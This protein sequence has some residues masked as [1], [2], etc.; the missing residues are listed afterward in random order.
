ML[1][2]CLSDACPLTDALSI[3]MLSLVAADN[4]VL[5]D[6]ISVQKYWGLVAL[7]SFNACVVLLSLVAPDKRV[8]KG[9]VPSLL[10]VTL[11]LLAIPLFL[12]LFLFPPLILALLE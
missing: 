1:I 10:F 4:K 3:T 7:A 8:A 11:L 5:E 9:V 2:R 12:L 6:D